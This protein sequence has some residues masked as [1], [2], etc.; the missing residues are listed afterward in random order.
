M[1]GDSVELTQE[2][3]IAVGLSASVCQWLVGYLLQ[4]QK[5]L[6]LVRSWAW[7]SRPMTA[8]QPSFTIVRSPKKWFV[9]GSL[10][11]QGGQA[12]NEHECS[13]IRQNPQG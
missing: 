7:T 12:T 9:S 8:S 11:S 4:P 13:R 3:S 2:L 1:S 5:I 10:A 6:L